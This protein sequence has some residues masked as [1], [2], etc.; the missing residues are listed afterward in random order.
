MRAGSAGSGRPVERAQLAVGWGDFADVVVVVAP[1]EELEADSPD[2]DDEDD[3]E[4]PEEE[5]AEEPEAAAEV[6]AGCLPRLS[7][8]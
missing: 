8:R 6:S 4:S 7:V 3:E 1:E 5:L 2:E